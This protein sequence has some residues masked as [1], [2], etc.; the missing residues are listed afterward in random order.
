MTA[1]ANLAARIQTAQDRADVG[2][3]ILEGGGRIDQQIT[4]KKHTVFQSG[5]YTPNTRD[6]IDSGVFLVASGV[7]VEFGR[8]AVV[9]QPDYDVPYGD[10]RVHATIIFQALESHYGAVRDVVFVRPRLR[11]KPM[12]NYRLSGVRQAI[13]LG[14]CTNCAVIE[15]DLKDLGSIGVQFGGAASKGNHAVHGLVYGGRFEH[16]A[17]A[18]IAIVN[19][20]DITVMKPTV[21]RP[22]HADPAPGGVS[23]VD[24]ETN[25][26]DDWC[27][28]LRVYN[29]LFDYTNALRY[30]SAVLAQNAYHVKGC[31]G[32]IIA[33]NRAVYTIGNTGGGLT[34]GIFFTG[35][36]PGGLVINNYIQRSLQAGIQLYGAAETLFQDNTLVSVGGGGL[37]AIYI[38]AGGRNVFRRTRI[39]VD[40]SLG[41]SV[42]GEI[43]QVDSPGNIF[44]P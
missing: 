12:T 7:Q 2:R 44:E 21:L 38:Q 36:F 40:E 25:N 17:A 32:L 39:T 26:T 43:K 30:G 24:I 20:R 6:I 28:D 5:E 27:A 9:W 33:N 19:G 14:N 8:T 31:T 29:G 35:A 1:G 18:A 37:P 15:A 13:S 23:G 4:L 3:I 42:S 11:A 10:G 41:G 34:S 16:I 22:G